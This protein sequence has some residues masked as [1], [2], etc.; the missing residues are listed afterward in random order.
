[1]KTK[2]LIL[3]ALLTCGTVMAEETQPAPERPNR[4]AR[5]IAAALLA[6]FDKDG[7]GRLN[8][9]ERAE[10]QRVMRERRE[11]RR[12]ELLKRFD[13]DGD[14]RLS[15]QERETAR[16]TIRREMLAKYDAN[17][18][19]ELDPEERR[20]MIEGEGHNPIAPLMRRPAQRGEARPRGERRQG[21]EGRPRGERRQGAEDRPRGE[22]RRAPQPTE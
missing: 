21:A 20:A 18:N 11:A 7:D 5:P 15:E 6:Q 12:Q 2:C 16:E 3:T 1:M 22:R 17:G 19:G 4:E 10:M 13:A 14:G 9:E 8:E